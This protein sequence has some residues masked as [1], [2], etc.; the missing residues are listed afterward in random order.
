MSRAE[1]ETFPKPQKRHN[2]LATSSNCAKEALA[3]RSVLG[4]LQ[5]SHLWAEAMLCKHTNNGVSITAAV[6][7]KQGLQFKS[8]TG[9]QLDNR[10]LNRPSV[11]SQRANQIPYQ[12]HPTYYKTG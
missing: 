1:K 7:P 10:L 6:Q 8:L 11:V 2:L 12:R 3:D 4:L 5:D 9:K